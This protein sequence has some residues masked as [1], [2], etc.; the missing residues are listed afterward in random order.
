[1]GTGEC[2]GKFI[3]QRLVPAHS[4]AF[5]PDGLLL[6][7]ALLDGTIELWDAK[8]GKCVRTLEGHSHDAN[9][10]VFSPDGRLIVT[11]SG[12]H[13]NKVWDT[14]TG[15]CVRTLEGHTREVNSVAFSPDGSLL[16]TASDDNTAKVWLNNFANAGLTLKQALQ[17]S[18][19]DALFV[20]NTRE[21]PPQSV[22]KTL[23]AQLV[24]DAVGVDKTREALST[25]DLLMLHQKELLKNFKQQKDSSSSAAAADLV[26]PQEN[27][28]LN[29]DDDADE[30]FFND[31]DDADDD[32]EDNPDYT[33][34]DED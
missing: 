5:S 26:K 29:N 9:S 4:V 2:V 7:T 17:L 1:V 15:L 27:S 30:D 12:D 8:T 11:A 13:T 20:Y 32:A 33:D 34:D 10:V 18:I 14:Q 21:L 25:E 28:S 19:Q 3:T 6:A 24:Q 16:A 22:S 31:D 23:A